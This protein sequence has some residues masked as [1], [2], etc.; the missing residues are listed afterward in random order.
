MPLWYL[1]NMYKILN[2]VTVRYLFRYL[3][4]TKNK[5]LSELQSIFPGPLDKTAVPKPDGLHTSENIDLTFVKD[6]NRMNA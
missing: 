4:E 1:L 5:S 3:P 6:E 2:E